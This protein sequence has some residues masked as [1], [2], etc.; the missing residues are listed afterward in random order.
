MSRPTKTA[1]AKRT[2][3][4]TIYLNKAEHEQLLLTADK[5]KIDKSRLIVKAL[6]SYFKKERDHDD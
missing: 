6:N 3:K 4:E 2:H 1:E 5:E